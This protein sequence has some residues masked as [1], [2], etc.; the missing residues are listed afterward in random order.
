MLI[1]F[2][3]ELRFFS[4]LNMK[5]HEL[6]VDKKKGQPAALQFTDKQIYLVCLTHSILLQ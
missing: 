4:M 5:L 6:Q 2:I 1:Y 3:T